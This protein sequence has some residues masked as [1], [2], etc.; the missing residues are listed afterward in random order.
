VRVGKGILVFRRRRRRKTRRMM[1]N[2]KER[3]ELEG[4]IRRDF[5]EE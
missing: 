1:E 3:K 4:R 2:H 5:E